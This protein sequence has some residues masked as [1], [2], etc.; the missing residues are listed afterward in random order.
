[1]YATLQLKNLCILFKFLILLIINKMDNLNFKKI[2]WNII[3]SYFNSNNY[4]FTN[5]QIESYNDF[6]GSKLPYTIKTLNP[7]T[8]LKKNVDTDELLYEVNVYIGGIDGDKIFLGKPVLHEDGSN[9]PFYPNEAKL[10]DMNYCSELYADIL[11]EYITYGK[12]PKKTIKEFKLRKLGLIPIMVHSNLCILNNQSS[13]VLTEMGECP[14]D[15]GG[16]FII[17]GKEKVIISQERIATNKIFITKSSENHFTYEATIR[18]TSKENILF[19]K[20]LMFGVYNEDHIKG[21]RKN[22]IVLTC[23]NI[24]KNIPIFVMF[25]ALGIESDKEILKYILYDIESKYNKIFLDFLRHSLIDSNYIYSQQQALEYLAPFTSYK[26]VDNVKYVLANDFLPNVG[27]DFNNKAFLLGYL[28]NKIIKTSIG[29]IPETNKDN[30]LF[31]RV[32]LSG[33]LLSNLFRDFYNKLRNNIKNTMDRQYNYGHWKNSGDISELINSNNIKLIFDNRIITEGMIKSLKGNWGMLNDPKKSGI[34]QDLNRL[35]YLGY[36]SHVRRINTPID[37][38]IKLEEPHRLGGT[39]FGSMCPIESPDGGNIG[40]L[41]HFPIMTIVSYDIEID[42]IINCLEDHKMIYLNDISTND[43]LEG[44]KIFINNNWIGIHLNPHYIYQLLINLRRI[45]VIHNTISISWYIQEN[46]LHILADAGRVL[47]PLYI[48]KN[49]KLLLDKDSIIDNIKNDNFEWSELTNKKN[50][51]NLKY[52]KDILEKFKNNTGKKDNETSDNEKIDF[53]KFNKLINLIEYI[54]IEESN[55]A[56]IAMNRKYLENKLNH[57]THCEIDPSTIL[58]VYSNI[59]PF[60]DHNPYPRNVFGAQQGKQAI[61]IYATNFN[62]RIDTASYIIHYPQRALV[63]TKYT[64]Y[65]HNE[66]LPNGEN[67]IVAIATYT[68]FNQEDSIIVNKSSIERG[69]FNITKFKSFINEESINKNDNEKTIFKN[70][71]DIVNNGTPMKFKLANWDYIDNEGIP[72]VNSYINDDDV[73]LGKVKIVE[74]FNESDNIFSKKISKTSY[75]DN[76]IVGDKINKGFIDKVFV[77]K[78]DENLNK[79]KIRFRKTMIPELGDKM[80]SRAG[81][82]GVC[83]MVYSEEDMPFNKDGIVPDIIINP[84]A[85]PS[86][87]TIGHLIECVLC[88]LGC[89]YAM[90]IDGT[91]FNNQKTKKLF[92]LLD[93][94]E[95]HKYGDEIMYNGFTGEQMPCH[96]F[97]GPTYYYRLKHMVSDKVNYRNK[98]GPITSTTKQ[99]TQGRANGGGLRIGEMEKDVLVAHGLGSFLKE[100]MMERS[101][102]FNYSIENEHGTIAIKTEENLISSFKDSDNLDFSNVETP[103]TFKLLLQELEGLSIKASLLNNDDNDTDA[104]IENSYLS[105]I[106]L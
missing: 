33:Y 5:I 79:V 4:Y 80:S 44:V 83:G 40:L 42:N 99:P 32:D 87:M 54:D 64:Q 68:G 24:E 27:R 59:I 66:E 49:N 31:K 1:L 84:H 70:P 103:Y 104:N 39:Q 11:I 75:I 30:Y 92:N 67:L 69:M 52:T 47:R 94:K 13:Q 81:Q 63:H 53:N 105:G 7:F 100:S 12:T 60:S 48:V 9:K 38:S 20:T 96:I 43:V 89:K 46:E 16:Y 78:N 74:E 97:F 6:I 65:T 25:R 91:T 73:L 95:I 17:S 82:K 98:N 19:P 8:M 72:I 85:I 56:L 41:K 61:G 22:A 106:K 3:N 15:Q 77:Y 29:I 37:R 34:V 21:V 50:N 10:K 57:Y 14:Y 90:S 45:G 23:P 2:D 76:S 62:N 18:C 58:S 71:I 55:N 101:D 35:S 26:N 88:K 93:K 86:R 28:V 102:K 36:L 51:Y